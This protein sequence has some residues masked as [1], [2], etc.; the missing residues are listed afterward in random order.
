MLQLKFTHKKKA[1]IAFVQ[2]ESEVYMLG[3]RNDPKKSPKL[4]L[5]KTK[6]GDVKILQLEKSEPYKFV[7]YAQR[8][9]THR[10][11]KQWWASV[12]FWLELYCE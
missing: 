2:F 8:L 4:F 11:I 5:E 12:N 10:K 3:F 7:D 1:G 6:Q 9:G